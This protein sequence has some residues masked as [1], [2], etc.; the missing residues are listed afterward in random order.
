MGYDITRTS[1]NAARALGL[2]LFLVIFVVWAAR[3]RRV[4][5]G[6][7][8]ATAALIAHLDLKYDV[9]TR[10]AALRGLGKAP[11]EE[12][13]RALRN[14]YGKEE[15]KD[16]QPEIVRTLFDH[17]LTSTQIRIYLSGGSPFEKFWGFVETFDWGG[18]W[19]NVFILLVLFTF[20]MLVIPILSQSMAG[21]RDNWGARIHRPQFRVVPAMFMAVMSL[22]LLYLMVEDAERAIAGFDKARLTRLQYEL[23]AHSP[24][25]VDIKWLIEQVGD[26]KLPD[27]LRA[28]AAR[29]VGMAGGSFMARLYLTDLVQVELGAESS[30]DLVTSWAWAVGNI[31]APGIRRE[32]NMSY[33]SFLSSRVEDYDMA[34]Q[35]QEDNPEILVRKARL[36]EEMGEYGQAVAAFN[37]AI[38][39]RPVRADL[40]YRRGQ[41]HALRGESTSAVDD[42]SSALSLST[43]EA[44][45]DCGKVAALPTLHLLEAPRQLA[46]D[47]EGCEAPSIQP[48]VD[49]VCARG[50]ARHLLSVDEW[51]S[52]LDDLT[53]CTILRGHPADAH[54]YRGLTLERLARYEEA[55]GA[56]HSYRAEATEYEVEQSGVQERIVHCR[57]I[58]KGYQP[59]SASVE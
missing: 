5:Q 27:A 47:L 23:A 26:T 55:L 25:P 20:G 4:E 49:A 53:A 46:A 3:Y 52:G 38:A 1:G 16:L 41:V 33:D 24:N 21:E 44:Y 42:F 35:L 13:I 50:K 28:E 10:A 59:Q 31:M 19:M 2:L 18:Q 12:A 37:K 34:L 54:L 39:L 11:K 30:D 6:E 7:G 48:V 58:L 29:A 45:R 14:I 43:V 57:E 15:Y 56:Y 17:G 8:I 40:L 22:L 36:L 51:A 32:K 9:E